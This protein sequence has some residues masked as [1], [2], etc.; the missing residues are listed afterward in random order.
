MPLGYIETI[1]FDAVVVFIVAVLLP[2]SV[3]LLRSRS[4]AGKFSG[5]AMLLVSMLYIGGFEHYRLHAPEVTSGGLRAALLDPTTARARALA[6]SI[7]A[8]N[9]AR[10]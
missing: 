3:L 1:A 4:A 6:G 9:A 5:A 7:T 2:A 8:S 10:K